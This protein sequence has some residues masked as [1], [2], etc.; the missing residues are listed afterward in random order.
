G[1]IADLERRLA[2]HNKGLVKSTRKRRPMKL[3][4]REVFED[5]SS[6]LK[7]ERFL[8]TG[9]GREYLRTLGY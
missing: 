2:E 7:R 4:Y 6:A 1:S 8:K 9:K 3:V 5:R